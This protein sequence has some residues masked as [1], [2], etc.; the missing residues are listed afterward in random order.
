VTF[1][2]AG[3]FSYICTPHPNMEGTVTV[4]AASSVG[5]PEEDL[6]DA[7]DDQVAAEDDLAATGD[8]PDTG[9]DVRVVGLTGLLMLA[10]GAAL[11]LRA[12]ARA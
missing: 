5:Q 8:L 12:R 10:L 9:S 7:E 6:Q 11:R 4:Q 3:T 2:E 1:D